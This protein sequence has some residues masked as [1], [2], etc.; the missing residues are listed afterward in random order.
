MRPVRIHHIFTLSNSTIFGKTL[1]NTKISFDYI[2]L[3]LTKKVPILRIIQQDRS[4]MY[5]LLH[6]QHPLFLSDFN[7]SSFSRKIFEKSSDIKR[8]G[9]PSR[10][11]EQFH[12]A[13]QTDMT[14]LMVA[15]HNFANAPTQ[16]MVML[17]NI[18]KC[19]MHM[20]FTN[21]LM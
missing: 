13:G 17:T 21:H 11:D 14:K 8:R 4:Q 2:L 19:K 20:F 5:T 9:N 1:L 16:C 7:G 3:L 10:G 12:E 15:F 6:R 18:C